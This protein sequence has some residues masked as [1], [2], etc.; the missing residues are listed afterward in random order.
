MVK[1]LA[2]FLT[3][4]L[5]FLSVQYLYP[6]IIYSPSQP[7][8]EQQ[9]TFNVSHPLGISSSSVEWDFGDGTSAKGLTTATKIYNQAGLYTVRVRYLTRS[10]VGRPQQQ[11]S[12]NKTI[13]IVERRKI[14]FSPPSSYVSQPVTF[15]AENFLSSSIWW[16]FG[17]GTAP[18]ISSRIVTHGYIRGGQ[19]RVSAKDFSGKSKHTFSVTV[20]VTEIR[21]PRAP[22]Q[23]YFIQ[24]RFEDGKSYKIV[25]KNFE[26][27]VVY[28]D[29]KYEGT[30]ILQGQWLV[31]GKPFSLIS[32]AL[33]FAKQTILNSGK[34]P[35]FPTQRQG[36][37]KVSLRI[38][39]PETKY[40]IPVI[41]YFV[42][43]ERAEEEKRIELKV[44][45]VF[46]L[47][48]RVNLLSYDSIQAPSKD[49]FILNGLIKN[50]E[51][52]PISFTLL[53]IY[54]EK[55]LIVQQIIKN[56]KP[57]EERKF[58]SSVYNPSPDQKRMFIALFDIS[59]F[60]AGFLSIKRFNIVSQK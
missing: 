22:F 26:P 11:I 37:H 44:L 27:L 47:E 34:I 52:K 19:Y 59:E 15:R 53:R 5:L 32:C 54:L 60:P 30:G 55:K 1:R 35:G 58:V 16:D 13:K 45:E 17:D 42:S 48:G 10:I 51:E 38:I 23:I 14:S 6:T 28:A 8:V 25:P 41:R 56:L 21:G 43:S 36:M 49:Y 18:E 20:N 57:S 7:N 3:A 31:D 46:D 12:E 29:I 50:E 33:P 9:V 24:L 40:T 2:L 4:G 39:H